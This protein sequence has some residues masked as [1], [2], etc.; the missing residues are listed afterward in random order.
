MRPPVTPSDIASHVRA[1]VAGSQGGYAWLY[2]TFAPLV[3]S[4]HLGMGTRALAD[5]LTQETFAL[6][7]SRLHALRETPKF[8]PWI[9]AIARRNLPRTPAREDAFDEEHEHASE[10]SGPDA[11]AE[12]ERVLRAIR[13]LPEAYR[14]TLLLRLVEG[15][16]GPEIAALTGLT[17]ASV[18]VNLHRGM[19]KLRTALGLAPAPEEM[20]D[21][22]A[23]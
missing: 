6:A 18:R 2:R 19:A 3:H 14:E 17:P 12:A 16:S 7:F 23:P 20:S 5:E 22:A 15:M 8:G 13:S 21:V 9:A 4:I 11:S 10:T 1:A